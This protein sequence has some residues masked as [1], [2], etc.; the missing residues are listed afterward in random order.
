MKTVVFSWSIIGLFILGLTWVNPNHFTSPDSA[1]YLGQANQF[2]A[3]QGIQNSTFPLGYPALLAV[4][5]WL[6]TLPP[7]WASKLVNWLFIGILGG[8][9]ARRLG[10]ARAGWLLSVWLL[11]G[12][13]RISTYTW[14]ETVFLV[15]LV[16][17]VWSI[18][19]SQSSGKTLLLTMGLFL[20]RY[21][22]GFVGIVLLV[23][24][25]QQLVIALGCLLLMSLY[26]GLNYYLTGSP[27]G[28][29]RFIGPDQAGVL[30]PLFGLAILNEGLLIRDFIPGEP[31]G[32]AWCGLMA[33]LIIITLAVRQYAK[34]PHVG[35]FALTPLARQF[36]ITG[37]VYILVLFTLR[38]ISPFAGPNARLMAPATCCLL[39][40]GLLWLTESPERMRA[41][42]PYWF[43]LIVAS[44]LQLLPQRDMAGKFL[45]WLHCQVDVHLCL[46][47]WYEGILPY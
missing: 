26:A 17:W 27:F 39:W 41:I 43:M 24:R 10:T 1:Y 9:W 18:H 40:A 20:V 15:L 22:G 8:L 45:Q 38:G 14:S 23:L 19:T 12:F 4:G 46:L 30:F 6:T 21:V 35:A 2:L 33:Q 28:G 47:L 36:L 32:L 31:N 42:R 44:W 25:P 29:G 7:L 3:G 16:E 13:L 37:L 34:I 5:S 11:G